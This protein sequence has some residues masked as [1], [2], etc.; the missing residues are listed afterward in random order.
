M[1]KEACQATVHRVTKNQT[2][3]KGLSSSSILKVVS[4]SSEHYLHMQNMR[5][6]EGFG[7]HLLTIS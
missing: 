5:T 3:L 4:P 6:A 2:R 7:G 1:D